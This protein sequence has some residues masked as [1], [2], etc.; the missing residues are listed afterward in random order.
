MRSLKG[1]LEEN[2]SWRVL[3]IRTPPRPLGSIISMRMAWEKH[4]T[5]N[6][7]LRDTHTTLD[8]TFKKVFGKNE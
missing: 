8:V 3:K 4:V 7:D 1:S 5:L 2:A 6:A